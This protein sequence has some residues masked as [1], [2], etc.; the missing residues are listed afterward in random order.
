MI[1]A[2]EKYNYITNADYTSQVVVIIRCSSA[3]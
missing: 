1:I 2:P 3:L